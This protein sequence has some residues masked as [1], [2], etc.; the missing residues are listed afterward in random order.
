MSSWLTY[1]YI[2]S[3]PVSLR[4]K[5]VCVCYAVYIPLPEEVAVT[6]AKVAKSFCLASS[7]PAHMYH[8]GSH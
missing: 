1:V 2:T 3:S 6:L 5:S 4:H 8:P 7:C